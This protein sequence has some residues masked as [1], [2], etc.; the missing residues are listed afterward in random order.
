MDDEE[1]E[2]DTNALFRAEMM[3]DIDAVAHISKNPCF[4]EFMKGPSQLVK[5]KATS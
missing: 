2:V 4:I 1:V 3:S 5:E